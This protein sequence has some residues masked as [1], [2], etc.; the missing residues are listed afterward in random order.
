MQ[1]NKDWDQDIPNI[2]VPCLG[3]ISW[4]FK[5]SFKDFKPQNYFYHFLSSFS[6]P[7]YENCQIYI[8]GTYIKISEHSLRL[9]VLQ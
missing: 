1:I 3:W 8:N 2:K 6:N 7:G 5:D 9:N 4:W